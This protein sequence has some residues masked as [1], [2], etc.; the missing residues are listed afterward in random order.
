MLRWPPI[1]YVRAPS[2]WEMHR[3]P[4]VHALTI[5]TLHLRDSHV[6][7]CAH[8]FHAMTVKPICQTTD[9]RLHLFFFP[10]IFTRQNCRK[11]R[12]SSDTHRG[13]KARYIGIFALFSY[14]RPSSRQILVR[15]DSTFIGS[16]TFTAL[17]GQYTRV[18]GS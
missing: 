18:N 12:R 7:L 1:C 10:F 4:I 3:L 2:C 5:V 8:I 13:D 15:Y 14:R 16:G 9:Q 17:H 11:G 6:H